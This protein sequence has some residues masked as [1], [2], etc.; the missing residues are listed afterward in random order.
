MLKRLLTCGCEINFPTALFRRAAYNRLGAFTDKLCHNDD[1]EYWMRL[2]LFYD[3][4]YLVTPLI[5]WRYH[6][7]SLTGQYIRRGPTG[8]S[9]EGLYEKFLAKPMILETYGAMIPDRH[10]LIKSV[11]R[12]ACERVCFQIDSMLDGRA[13]P[14]QAPCVSP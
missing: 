6:T 5:K 2:A 12:E 13:P 7:G 1:Y 4:A 10:N 11:H 9:C 8:I 3:I 14:A